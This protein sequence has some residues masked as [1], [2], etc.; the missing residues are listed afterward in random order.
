MQYQFGGGRCLFRYLVYQRYSTVYYYKV[1]SPTILPVLSLTLTW[2]IALATIIP[3]IRATTHPKLISADKAAT[4]LAPFS[5]CLMADVAANFNWVNTKL[6][7]SNTLCL[8]RPYPDNKLICKK[9]RIN[10]SLLKPKP[11]G[12]TLPRSVSLLIHWNSLPYSVFSQI[13]L[14]WSSVKWKI[15]FLSVLSVIT[16]PAL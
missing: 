15:H 8:V 2:S 5:I 4:P 1:L 7:V 6:V 11:K 16:E 9:R 14:S 3:H 13:S 12:R 10:L